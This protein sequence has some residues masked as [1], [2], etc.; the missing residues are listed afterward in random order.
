MTVGSFRSIPVV[1]CRRSSVVTCLDRPGPS[2]T[3]NDGRPPGPLQLLRIGPAVP[4]E[5]RRIGELFRTVMQAVILRHCGSRKPHYAQEHKRSAII[6]GRFF[7][8]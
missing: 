2:G 4:D 8:E 7:P 1:C 6:G 5:I 3:A